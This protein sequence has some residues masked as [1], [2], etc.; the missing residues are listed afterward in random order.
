MQTLKTVTGHM[1]G[2][3]EIFD[4]KVVIKK[5][6]LAGIASKGNN[7]KEIWMKAITGVQITK[8]NIFQ[9]GKFT[10]NSSGEN[11]NV[12]RNENT[13]V[14]TKKDLADFEAAKDL[15]EQLANK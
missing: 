11:G 8:P 5:T 12:V 15:I 4:N 10:V 14:F 13:V 2:S 7:N 6:G 1:G 9:N 3:I